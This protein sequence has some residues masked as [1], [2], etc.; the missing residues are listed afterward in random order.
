[1]KG[2]QIIITPWCPFCG[3]KVARPQEAE[4]RKLGEFTVGRC[5]CD[6]VYACDATGHNIGSAMIEA[7]LYACNDDWDL[8]WSLMPEDDYLTGQID[9]YDEETHQVV[10]SR[11][12]EGRAV[13]GV[14]FFVRLHK[15][16][17]EVAEQSGRGKTHDA[18]GKLRP[19]YTGPP[20]EPE[21]DPKR[22]RQKATKPL[23][24]KLT[25]D[26]DI[27]GLVDL[28]FDDI[29]TLSFLQRLLYSPDDA[30][31]WR[32]INV[33]GKTC[34]RFSTRKPGPV[35]DLLHRM[36]AAAS[37][38]ASSSWGM[39][40]AIGAIIA[41]RPDIFGP[42]AQHLLRYLN[43]DST[44]EVVLWSLGS[45]A[46]NE[47]DLI[48]RTLPF[49]K[50]FVYT[51]HSKPQIRA[52]ALRLF[53]Y[54]KASEHRSG[55]EKLLTDSSPV[56]IYEDGI[57]VSTSVEKLAAKTIEILDHKGDEINE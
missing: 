36:F 18:T 21:R 8:S 23:V 39:I 54:T 45:I 20:L 41:E 56:V 29:K 1:M 44:V 5:Q 47:P 10:E 48:R 2:Q 28:V 55:I 3:Q 50:F 37:D 6:A 57:A 42:F 4:K 49:F 30:R 53:S 51:G 34:A 17:T 9:D 52:Q 33:L 16:I 32:A 22:K 24:L 35:S 43:N 38:S 46:K 7:L 14:L 11:N 27:D 12:L 15:D 13:R 25:E 40:E 19:R 26:G 31:R